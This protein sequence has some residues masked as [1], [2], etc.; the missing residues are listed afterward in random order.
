MLC[1]GLAFLSNSTL[2][3]CR[4]HGLGGV[5]GSPLEVQQALDSETHRDRDDRANE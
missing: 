2:S 4:R 5:P 1:T 3:E